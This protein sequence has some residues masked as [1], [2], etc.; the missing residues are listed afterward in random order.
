MR[1]PRE[2]GIIDYAINLIEF[3]EIYRD[4]FYFALRDTL[5]VEDLNTARR[6]TGK[7]RMVT[8]DG[9]VIEKAGS[10]TGRLT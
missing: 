1:L 9:S 8:L 5:I 10:M 4:A 7:F 6:L 3:D 2:K